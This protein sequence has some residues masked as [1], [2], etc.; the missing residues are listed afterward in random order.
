MNAVVSTLHPD[1]RLP[2]LIH[3]CATQVDR[4]LGWLGRRLHVEVVGIERLPKGRALLVANHA[5]GWDAVFAMR[6]I[7]RAT[8]RRVWVLGEHLWWKFPIL[9]EV[10]AAMGT[11]DGTPA[12]ADE[13]LARDELVLVLPGGL[14]E[15]I[16]PRE[17]RYR[18]LWGHRFGFVRLALRNH[19]PLVPLASIGADEMFD[20]VGQPYARGRRWIPWL[21]LPLPRP[22]YGLPILHPKPLR[23]VIGD[24]IEVPSQAEPGEVDPT[25][26]RRLRWEIT[27][28]LHELLDVELARRHGFDLQ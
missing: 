26:L 16:K 20:L 24:P 3:A 7:E 4:L 10:A 12:N 27:G 8:G 11:V 13:L 14:R 1:G 17:L 9:R 2:P 28:A 5:F 6:E 22:A 25:V 15:A 18:L 19:A 21:G 23:Y